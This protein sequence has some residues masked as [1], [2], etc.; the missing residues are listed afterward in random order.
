MSPCRPRA[1]GRPT[2]PGSSR[3]GRG[4][5]HEGR[6]ARSRRWSSRRCRG[7]SART[8]GSS[9]PSRASTPG[10]NPSTST[11]AC[12]ASSSARPR[13][14]ASFR[15]SSRLRLPALTA[16]K[17][18]GVVA[19][20]V[21]ARRLDLQHVGAQGHQQRGGVRP[22]TPDAQVEHPQPGEKPVVAAI[23]PESCIRAAGSLA[24]VL[25]FFSF[26]EVTDPSAHEAYNAWHQLDHLPEQ[27]TIDG[28]LFGR[29]WVRSP[30]C[31]AAEAAT[32][33]PPR[34]VPLHD[35]LPPPRRARGARVLRPGRAAA[36]RGPLLR[37]AARPAVGALRRGRPLGRT[38]R[39]R[40]RPGRSRS[41]RRR[42]STWSWA[43]PSTGAE[44]VE[45]RRGGGRLAVRRRRAATGPSRWPS[46]TAT[47]GRPPP[48]SEPAAASSPEWAGPLERVDAFRWDW[49]AT[50]TPQ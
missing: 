28:I 43:R 7:C 46:S 20:R 40:L 32:S 2:T 50:L 47:C 34:P 38:P 39:R 27:F 31:R 35:A 37:G 19:H 15:S 22:G 16:A 18:P 21:A 5:R 33:A 14:A 3:R 25:G 44:L 36:R 30:R 41:A 29:R 24:G 13:S 49:F 26:T 12:V 6:A 42:G 9:S 17:R 10:R 48:P 4:G 23:G 45:P 1:S 8:A 11:S